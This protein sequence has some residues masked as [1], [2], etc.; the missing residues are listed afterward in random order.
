MT[1]DAVAL[2]R[3]GAFRPPI[4][5]ADPLKLGRG[6]RA[7]ECS[8]RDRGPRPLTLSTNGEFIAAMEV[9]PR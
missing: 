4:S 8:V 3:V 9:R 2:Q 6:Q 7:I 1:A 5:A